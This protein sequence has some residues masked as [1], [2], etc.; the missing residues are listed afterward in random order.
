MKDLCGDKLEIK[1]LTCLYFYGKWSIYHKKCISMIESY[2]KIDQ[3]I[4]FIL[5]DV[6]VYKNYVTQF[7]VTE[8]PT[9]IFTD[10]KKV[11]RFSGI[12]LTKPFHSYCKKIKEKNDKRRSKRDSKGTEKN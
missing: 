12:V 11:G 3:D 10:G 9:F 4:D 2:E 5:I 7:E 8:V 1:K 6:D